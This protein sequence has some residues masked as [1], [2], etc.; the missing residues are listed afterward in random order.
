MI[1]QTFL[2]QKVHLVTVVGK[3]TKIFVYLLLLV[4]SFSPN[5]CECSVSMD[6][7][8]SYTNVSCSQRPPLGG[9]SSAFPN[10]RAS[11]HVV[12]CS[13]YVANPLKHLFHDPL[14]WLYSL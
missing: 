14:M 5:L 11:T 13:A 3:I 1:V 6:S 9:T 2:L 12:Q 7:I 8:P 10:T 4:K